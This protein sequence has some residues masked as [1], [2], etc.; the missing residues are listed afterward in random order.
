MADEIKKKED[1]ELR[2]YMKKYMV[3]QTAAALGGLILTGLIGYLGKRKEL[4]K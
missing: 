1:A 4:R 2:E 3:R